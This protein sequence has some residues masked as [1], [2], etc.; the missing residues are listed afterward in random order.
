[1][2]AG[3]VV[4]VLPAGM[5]VGGVCVGG[6]GVL[7]MVRAKSEGILE[8][9]GVSKVSCEDSD[10]GVLGGDSTIGLNRGEL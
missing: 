10:G 1:M 2:G 6:S 9:I 7:G 5:V 3:V 8:G 4:E